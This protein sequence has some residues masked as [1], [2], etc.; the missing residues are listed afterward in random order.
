MQ[1]VQ[2]GT[3]AAQS[4]TAGTQVGPVHAASTAAGIEGCAVGTVCG[5]ARPV[6][7]VGGM[8]NTS[9][10]LGGTKDN[11][12]STHAGIANSDLSPHMR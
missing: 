5:I 7:T 2:T 4:G 10:V 3:Y 11:T 8:A 12:A 6:R 1:L 9:T